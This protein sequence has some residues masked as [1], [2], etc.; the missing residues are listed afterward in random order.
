[1]FIGELWL[2]TASCDRT[3]SIVATLHRLVP[4]PSKHHSEHVAIIISIEVTRVI[5]MI[6]EAPAMTVRKNLGELL[7]E[8]QYRR[9]SIVITKGGKP[10]AALVD[11]ELFERI[12][13]LEVEFDRLTSELAELYSDVDERTTETEI[14]VAVK[15]ARRKRNSK[16]T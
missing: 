10:V 7:N 13:L 12:R 14:N 15:A 2:L 4:T 11:V 3:F 9:D 8:I 16:K 6:R 5:T 1:M